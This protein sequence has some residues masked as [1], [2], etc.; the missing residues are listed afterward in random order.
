MLCIFLFTGLIPPP[1]GEAAPPPDP[2][3]LEDTY[4]MCQNVR[5]RINNKNILHCT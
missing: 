5:D 2:E 4:N 3:V 1:V